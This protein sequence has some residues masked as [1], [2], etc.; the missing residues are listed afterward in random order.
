MVVNPVTKFTF[1][2]FEAFDKAKSKKDK[3]EV[4]QNH[5]TPAVKNILLGTFDNSIVWALPEGTP[6]YAPADERSNANSFTRQLDQ[7]R[8]FV[9]GGPGDKLTKLK[10][11]TMFV[12]L[13]ESIHPKDAELVLKMV[14]KQPPAK[15]L[16]KALVQEVFPNLIRS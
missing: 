12:R 8:Y 1:E 11:E 13:L 15:G 9:V 3:V 5:A 7:L 14:A 16:T 6:P 2:V 4:L 10:R